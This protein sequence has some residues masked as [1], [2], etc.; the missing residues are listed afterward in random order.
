MPKSMKPIIINVAMLSRQENGRYALD[1]MEDD[2]SIEPLRTHR[3]ELT[4]QAFEQL[5]YDTD[6]GLK[7]DKLFGAENKIAP[8]M[9]RV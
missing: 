1:L 6:E 8:G 5:R 7:D 2:G 4:E 9:Y 3:F